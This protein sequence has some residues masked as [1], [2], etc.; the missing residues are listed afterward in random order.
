MK[1]IRN[2]KRA[3]SN[4]NRYKKTPEWKNEKI[5]IYNFTKNFKEKTTLLNL[6]HRTPYILIDKTVKS[7]L[8]KKRHNETIRYSITLNEFKINCSNLIMTLK[9]LKLS[10]HSF[11]TIKIKK[12]CI[13]KNQK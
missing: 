1:I 7:K 12:P 4:K 10:A 5:Y 6:V 8:Q 13:Q 9:S 11:I 2:G 3:D